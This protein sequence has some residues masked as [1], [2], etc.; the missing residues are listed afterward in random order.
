LCL[1]VS[2]KFRVTKTRKEILFN[3]CQNLKLDIRFGKQ[4]SCSD[5]N[6][7]LKFYVEK[8]IFYFVFIG[9]KSNAFESP[10]KLLRC[11]PSQ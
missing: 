5:E 3:C 1:K 7:A 8:P 2:G 9:G 4:K 10:S 6:A 11:E